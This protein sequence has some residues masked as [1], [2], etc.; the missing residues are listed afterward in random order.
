MSQVKEREKLIGV[1]DSGVGGLTVL[2]LAAKLLPAENYIYFGDTAHAPY[3]S[4]SKEEVRRLSLA[5]AEML[6]NRGCKALVVACNTATSAAVREL[7]EIYSVPVIG[8]E[9]AVK[10]ALQRG[11]KVLVM[12]TPLTL[13]EEKFKRLC[14]SCG[15]D[16]DNVTV[17]PCPGLVEMVERGET[18]GPLVEQTLARLFA[19]VDLEGITAVVLGC[20]HY[21]FLKKA[22][23][24]IL[25]VGVEFV[26]GN[27]GTVKQLT[28][29]L[30]ANKLLRDGTVAGNVELLSSG[31]NSS[32]VIFKKLYQIALAETEG[33]K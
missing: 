28:R 7:R 33:L 25:P 17:L 24:R 27:L 14:S 26:D 8:M 11:G 9:P 23:S 10:P 19:G 13:K 12:A 4:R 5:A 16:Q 3:G 29:L 1:F 30:E 6:C 32:I 18:E 15:A 22:L 31:G 21:L 2:A 20:T